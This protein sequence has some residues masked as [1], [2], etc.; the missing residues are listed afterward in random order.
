MS[1]KPPLIELQNIVKCYARKSGSTLFALR[2]VSLRVYAGDFVCITGPSGSGKSTLLHILG[3]LDKA[4]GGRYWFAGRDIQHFSSDDMAWLRRKAFGFVFQN[5]NLLGS[6]TAIENVELPGVYARTG[7]DQRRKRALGLLA[8]LG[9]RDR[10]RHR[11]A[12]LSGGQQQRV[13]I[14]RALMNGGHVILADEPTGALDWQSSNEVLDILENLVRRGHTVILISH[15]PEIAIRAHRCIKLL[16]GQVVADSGSVASSENL[17]I[18][19]AS[20]NLPKT[21]TNPIDRGMEGLRTCVTSLKVNLLGTRRVRTLFA[22]ISI[23][24]GVWSVVS[25]LMIAEGLFRQTVEQVERLGA[26]RVL[27]FPERSGNEAPVSLSL[28]DAKAIAERVPN[29]RKVLTSQRHRMTVSFG[30]KSIEGIVQSHLEFLPLDRREVQLPEVELGSSIRQQENDTL[31]QVAV[32]GSKIRD[33]LFPPDVSPVGQQLM[34]GDLPFQVKGIIASRESDAEPRAWLVSPSSDRILIPYKTGTALLF[35]TT[36]PQSLEIFVYDT[37]QIGLT[38]VAVRRLLMLRHAGEGFAVTYEGERVER[39]GQ[40]RTKL[41]LGLGSIG[42]IAL[43]AGGMGVMAAMLMAVSERKKEIGIRMAIGARC[44][45]IRWQFAMEALLLTV[46][47]GLLGFVVGAATG[48]L[49]RLFNFS[50]AFSPWII[51]VALACTLCTGLVFGILPARRAARIEPVV[52]LRHSR[53]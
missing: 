24:I 50:A 15:N 7:V 42:G 29:V 43:F 16:D 53:Q 17:L 46:V 37:R 40:V 18:Q 23:V 25:M 9:L 48:P 51:L 44:R 36:K 19:D 38:I 2:G 30:A 49:A 41:L 45:D 21:K 52:A 13:A 8:M 12:A 32:I 26:D 10:I 27:V 20:T 1:R 35:G 4:D 5:Y 34:I 33:M 3:C 47:G 39:A 31:A 28:E 14:A 22:I 11:P 6:A